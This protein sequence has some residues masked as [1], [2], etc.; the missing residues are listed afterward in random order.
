[1]Q[2]QLADCA[3]ARFFFA[4]RFKGEFPPARIALCGT[5]YA[6]IATARARGMSGSHWTLYERQ[7]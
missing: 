2:L 4:D 7:P 3:A 1:L 6:P 5:V